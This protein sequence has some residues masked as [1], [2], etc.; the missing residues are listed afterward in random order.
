[1]RICVDL[2]KLYCFKNLGKG[3]GHF[4]ENKLKFEKLNNN[5]NQTFDNIS[6]QPDEDGKK[7]ELYSNSA[8]MRPL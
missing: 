4:L 3:P 5:N 2:G 6:M 8:R 7:N 1:M